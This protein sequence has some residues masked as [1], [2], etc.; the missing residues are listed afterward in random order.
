MASV[1]LRQFAAALG[2]A[3]PAPFYRD[4]ACW[5]LSSPLAVIAAET[6]AML[7]Q[8]IVGGAFVSLQGH[9]HA[10]PAANAYARLLD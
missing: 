5:L 1:L 3:M 6:K 7:G 10:S 8:V 4:A 9:V 2:Y